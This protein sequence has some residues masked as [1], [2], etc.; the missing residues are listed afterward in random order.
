[1]KITAQIFSTLFWFNLGVL[2][3]YLTGGIPSVPFICTAIGIGLVGSIL[4]HCILPYLKTHIA[5]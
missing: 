2:F 1:M 4:F 5:P 3:L